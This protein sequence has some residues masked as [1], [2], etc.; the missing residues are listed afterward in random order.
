MIEIIDASLQRGARVLLQQFSLRLA[1]PGLYLL[2]GGNGSGKSLLCSM[3]AGKCKP[4][5]GRVLIDGA[6]L[7][8]M[9]GGYAQPVLLARALAPLPLSATLHEYLEAQLGLLN[10]GMELLKPLRPLLEENLGLGLAAPLEQCSHGQLLIAQTA[11]AAVAPVRLALLDGHLSLLDQRYCRLAS[12]LLLAGRLEEKFVV[13]ATTRMAAAISGV[14][15]TITLDGRLPVQLSGAPPAGGGSAAGSSR[16]VRL[17]L[18]EW[19]PGT[20]AVTSGAAYTLLE[21]ME[22]GLRIK[23]SG[24]LDEVLAELRAHGIGV[25]SVEWEGEP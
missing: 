3:L 17:H 24:G 18:R 4:Q 20:Q 11:L 14:R 15:E 22:D 1:D 16:T 19:V 12:Q 7:Y 8:R 2:L 5:R 23:L 6:P 25:T 9:L 21:Q 13:L 10:A